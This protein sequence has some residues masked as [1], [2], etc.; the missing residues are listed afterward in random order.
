MAVFFPSCDFNLKKKKSLE[1]L[2]ESGGEQISGYPLQSGT[3]L[4]VPGHTLQVFKYPLLDSVVM[5]FLSPLES[6][7]IVL[8]CFPLGL[9]V[10]AVFSPLMEYVQRVF[11]WLLSQTLTSHL[12][13]PLS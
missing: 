12:P 2:D 3:L 13:L 10:Y 5:Y 9:V 11:P 1:S 4:I 8:I 7:P 6:C